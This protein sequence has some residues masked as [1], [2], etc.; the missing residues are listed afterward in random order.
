MI[1]FKKH[2]TNSSKT[3][4]TWSIPSVLSKELLFAMVAMLRNLT[5][6]ACSL[7]NLS[8]QMKALLASPRQLRLM[9][10][11]TTCLT[12]RCTQAVRSLR[13]NS[14]PSSRSWVMPS[15]INSTL[16]VSTQSS[17]S[18]TV[19]LRPFQVP[20]VLPLILQPSSP[21]VGKSTL[22]VK[23]SHLILTSPRSL[24]TRVSSS[25]RKLTRWPMTKLLLRLALWRLPRLDRL[26]DFSLVKCSSMKPHP[27]Q[28]KS[29]LHELEDSV[30]NGK[31]LLF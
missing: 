16:A 4:A 30:K 22:P 5:A 8:S 12:Q 18:W 29:T 23:A 24:S 28:L 14:K 27:P 21:S 20:S 9:F 2:S 15:W 26:L 31:T 11:L 6:V 13:V 3:P 1:L 19:L 25:W 10:W 7:S 17:W